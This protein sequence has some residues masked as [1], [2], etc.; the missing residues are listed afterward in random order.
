MFNMLTEQDLA[1][2]IQPLATKRDLDQLRSE[3]KQ[4]LAELRADTKQNMVELGDRL[5][6]VI[7]DSQTEVHRAFYDWARPVEARLNRV[8]E[9]AQRMSWLEERI[10]EIERGKRPLP[11]NPS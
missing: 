3:T 10:G 7:R 1:K 6:E 11:N 2:A 4:D 5:T 8:D 9:L